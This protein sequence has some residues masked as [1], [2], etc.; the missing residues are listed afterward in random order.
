MLM[1]GMM[2]GALCLSLCF[3]RHQGLSGVLQDTPVQTKVLPT[4]QVNPLRKYTPTWEKFSHIGS[5]MNYTWNAGADWL[6]DYTYYA[7]IIGDDREDWWGWGLSNPSDGDADIPQPKVFR[8]YAKSNWTMLDFVKCALA[9][10]TAMLAL[11]VSMLHLYRRERKRAAREP[12]ERFRMPAVHLTVS[13]M[14]CCSLRFSF[15]ASQ[16]GAC[17][18]RST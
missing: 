14:L 3:P 12:K 7:E 8:A 1:L 2:H 16:P 10:L 4:Y 5:H 11:H 9:L 15:R 18:A 17:K 13:G 6:D